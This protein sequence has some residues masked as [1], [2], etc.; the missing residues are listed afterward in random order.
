MTTPRET[1]HAVVAAFNA[2]D[3]STLAGFF[4][5]DVV[6]VSPDTKEVK[7]REQATEWERSLMDTFP[8]AMMEIAA[9]YDSGDTVV[10]EW[11]FRGTNTGPLQLPS[12]ETLPATGKQVS[13]R[14]VDI[15]TIENGAVA[16]LHAY[17]DQLELMTQLGLMPEA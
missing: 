6:I 5:P 14:G 13:V 1:V 4:T 2:H 12:G 10:L 17:W 15:S 3:L 7:G 11:V 8:D 9:S 16:S